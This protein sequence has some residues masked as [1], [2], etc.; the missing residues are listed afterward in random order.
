MFG[1]IPGL[2]ILFRWSIFLSLCQY[3]TVLMTVALQYSL[4]SGRLIAPFPF[5]FLKIALPIRGFMYFQDFPGGSD[6]KASVYNVGDPGS[7]PGL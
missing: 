3:H 1:F 7:I 6:G 5:F 2:S 4:K